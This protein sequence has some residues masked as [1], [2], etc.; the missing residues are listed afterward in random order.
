MWV[1]VEEEAA[2]E[3]GVVAAGVGVCAVADRVAHL[4]EPE[5]FLVIEGVLEA[6]CGVSGNGSGRGRGF[7]GLG[8][9]FWRRGG[10]R[11]YVSEVISGI[12]GRATRMRSW[13]VSDDTKATKL[14]TSSEVLSSA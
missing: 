9:G 6:V 2:L 14:R 8:V 12:R 11:A 3:G 7:F 1:P 4:V 10:G 13:F 5:G